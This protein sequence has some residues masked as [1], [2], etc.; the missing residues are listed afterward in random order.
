MLINICWMM[1]ISPKGRDSD[2]EAGVR[3]QKDSYF[4]VSCFGS[5]SSSHFPQPESAMQWDIIVV[6]EVQNSTRKKK[7]H[8]QSQ[9]CNFVKSSAGK[10]SVCNS[11]DPGW[12]P[13]LG[14]SPGEGI[15]YPLQYSCLENPMDRGAW[16]ATIHR[17]TKSWPR[18]S[19]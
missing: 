4:L 15:S 8:S 11:G 10:E 13:E 3:S 18:L 12:I 7:M 2:R 6:T 14:R 17:V 9:K 1:E 19:D 16:Q 5:V